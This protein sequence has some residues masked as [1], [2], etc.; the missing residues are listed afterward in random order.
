MPNFKRM[1][2]VFRENS[3]SVENGNVKN[4]LSFLTITTPFQEKSTP[5]DDSIS[6]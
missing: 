6:E 4:E 2:Y 3:L 1:K 5:D